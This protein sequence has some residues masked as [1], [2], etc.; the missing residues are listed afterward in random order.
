MHATAPSTQSA[1]F[2][3]PPFHAE[4]QAQARELAARFAARHR[5]IRSYPFEHGAQHPE[6]WQ[7]IRERGWAGL[8]VAP[9]DGGSEGGL[10]ALV[11]VM[12][13]LAESNLI[14]WMPVLT[15]AIGHAIAQVGPA[16]ARERWLSPIASGESL[17]AL[18]VTEPQCGHNVFR[19]KTTVA[20]DDDCF[21]VDGVKA[22]TSGIDLAERV[23]VFGRTP[24]EDG[25]RA[26][27]TTVLVDPDAPGV[28]RV[29]LPMRG[30]EGV[31]QFQLKFASVRAPLDGLV[32]TEGQG[33]LALWPFTHIE[34]LLTAALSLGNA[35][36]CV[37]RALAR[38]SE[39]TIFG[40]LPIGAEQSIQHP[41]A[42][43]HA[44]IEATRLLVYRAAQRFD[45]GA[46]TMATA[47]E[48]NMA[49]LL[50]ADL[51]FDSA[52]HAMQTLGAAAWDEREGMLDLYLDARAARSAPISQELA[53]NFIAQHVLGLP[54]HR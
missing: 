22:V 39:R 20:R 28:E 23:L 3:L 8:L 51:L 11:L 42:S 18:A 36:Y 14:L 35:R 7:E 32:G 31:R 43:L 19:S 47:G 4:L 50:S 2:E 1:P 5:E 6:L 29:E 53:S 25:A 46:D 41:L 10:L 48:A 45:A 13:A 34:R 30:R 40:Q 37:S 33:L 24:A 12:E 15:A 38:A 54:S 9:A 21:V 17:L 52:D 16:P 49:K 44:R 27:F 26:R